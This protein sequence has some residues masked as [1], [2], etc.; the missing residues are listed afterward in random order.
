MRRQNRP[1]YTF[2]LAFL[3]LLHGC[4][5]QKSVLHEGEPYTQAQ[6]ARAVDAAESRFFTIGFRLCAVPS[7]P[8]GKSVHYDLVLKNK[9]DRTLRNVRIIIGLSRKMCDAIASP[10]WYNEHVDIAAGGIALYSWEPQ[11]ILSRAI[12]PAAEDM[13][14]MLIEIVWQEGSELIRLQANEASMPAQFGHLLEDLPPL[15]ETSPGD[16]PEEYAAD[17]R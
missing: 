11:I 17:Q 7:S 13:R 4:S 9:T 14:E 15:T 10:I 2:L 3:L 5:A 12:G 16:P 1:L 6:Y 8:E